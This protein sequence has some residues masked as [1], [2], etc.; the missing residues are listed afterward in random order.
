MAL[1]GIAQLVDHLQCGIHSGIVTDGIIG[2]GNVVVDGAGQADH[3]DAAVCHLTGTTVRA[4]TTNDDQSIDAE[5]TALCSA[6]ILTL[7]GLELQAAGR[8]QDGATGRDDIGNAA[9]VHFKALAIQQ[10]IVAALNADHTEALVQAC[11]DN[12]ANCS[13]HTRSVAAAGQHTNRFDLLFHGKIPSNCFVIYL[14]STYPLSLWAPAPSPCS[15]HNL[16]LD[17]ITQFP[18]ESNTFLALR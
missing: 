18:L 14:W 11:T 9:Q 7:F 12:G 3:R 2:A 6:L 4:V 8:I 10:A 16:P 13:I 15:D 1:G 17:I 5:L